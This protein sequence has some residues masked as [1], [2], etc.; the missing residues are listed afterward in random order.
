MSKKVTLPPDAPADTEGN[1][2]GG[3]WH[4]TD[5]N[6]KIR[7]QLCPRGCVLAPGAR[8]FCFVRQNRNG[9]LVLTTYGRSTGF[10]IDP[11]E[12]KPLN[13]FY[14]GTPILSFG[15]AGCNLGCKFCQNWTTTKS[16]EVDAYCD[17]A[18][19]EAIAE[20]A[21]QH[22]CR[23]VAFTYN[24]P[25]VWAEYAIDTAKHCR[26]R[27]IKTV[28]VTSGYISQEAR[29]PFFQ[30]MD[31]ANVDLKGFTE[32][33]YSKY[34]AGHLQPVLDTLQWLV[35]ESNVWV[36]ITNLIIPGANDSPEQLKRMCQWIASELGPDVPLHFTAFHP[37]FR[38]L[39]TPP[40]PISMLNAAYDIARGEGL[41]Y[42]YTGNVADAERQSTYCP[43]CGRV[44][45]ERNGYY[46]G[47]YALE[48]NRCRFC[49]T[50]IAGCYD[51]HGPGNWGGRRQPVRIRPIVRPNSPPDSQ[52]D[53]SSGNPASSSDSSPSQHR[54]RGGGGAA[55][56]E[57]ERPAAARP[58]KRTRATHTGKHLPATSTRDNPMEER[59]AS[60]NPSPE[61]PEENVSSED[62]GLNPGGARPNRPGSAGGGNQPAESRPTLTPE[63][64]QQLLQ[65]AAA[66]IT[67]SVTAGPTPAVHEALGPVARVPVL[68]V[69]VS[70]KR[71]GQ[72]R[73]CCGHMGQPALLG[74]AI[75]QAAWRT[76]TSDPRF[77][78]ISPSELRH[79][80][81]ELWVLWGL[82]R[83]EARGEDRAKWVEIG[84]HGL[85]IV[86]GGARGLLLPGVAVEHELDSVGFL[87]QVCL[88]AGLPPDAWKS[89]EAVV[90]T[91][92]GYPIRAPLGQFV[93]Q[94]PLEPAPPGPSEQQ[95]Q[96]VVDWCRQNL[97]ATLVGA[98][99]SFYLPGGYDD[100]VCGVILRVAPAGLA[101]AVE[102]QRIV[103]RPELPFQATLYDLVRAAAQALQ[104]RGVGAH[105]VQT[106]GLLVAVLWDTAMHGSLAAAEVGDLNTTRRALMVVQQNRW[107]LAFDPEKDPQQ[108]LAIAGQQVRAPNR[109][110]ASVFSFRIASTEHPLLATNVARPQR[111]PAVRR[112]A[113]AGRFY[114]G[115][116]QKLDQ[117]L[118][119]LLP[120]ERSPQPWPGCLVPHAGWQYSGRLAAAVLSRVKI[121]DRVIVLAPKH[122]PVGADWAIAP[123][124]T[125][126]LPGR[127]IASDPDLAGRL[128]EAI[129]GLELDAAAHSQEHAIEVQL[130][131]LARLAPE[132]KVLGITIHG[133][134]FE[135]LQRFAEQLAGV[136]A[137]QSE[138]PLLVVS[139]D[140]NHYADETT[141]RRLD[142]MALD[143]LEALDPQ[144]L[145]NTV[146]Q[147]RISMCGVIPT[148]VM[149]I[150]LKEL[151]RLQRAELVGYTTSAETT[152]DSRRVVGYA[153]MLFG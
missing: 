102:V 121:P 76:A 16:R 122:R 90:M 116:Q 126:A 42:V 61:K 55:D 113:V 129:D 111:G 17:T 115:D 150:A 99:P 68:G 69:F 47:Q 95:L 41:H 135:A 50:T 88:K 4:Q 5:E 138:L 12:K 106:A 58:A 6:G 20:A 56:S 141:T 123:H 25:I 13:Q 119:Q 63:Q 59:P 94:V 79:L 62:A 114:P 78:P 127:N 148:V 153:G 112:P 27:G 19:P 120:G 134:D 117:A 40:T 84:K 128:A 22:G 91:F 109:Q 104:R 3:W 15:T 93:G 67:A 60:G 36:E 108:L 146:H 57:Q 83:I 124:Q 45:I 105:V 31:A 89:N 80:D 85:Q 51:E 75:L 98:T 10:C 70:L 118:D 53:K 43:N 103:L 147:Q 48:G 35:H 30:W 14:P 82:K 149:M 125:W 144:R 152:R 74:E 101:E 151:G 26:R 65:Q 33:F 46:L 87:E 66:V 132:A 21:L 38:M 34:C 18:D 130:P 131:L 77:P 64:E 145:Y 39:D 136:L 1:K 97:V 107:A 49:G 9:E 81:M 71:A 139:T 29:E 8:G 52:L 140:M 137:E 54:R 32:D 2:P 37:D 44:I 96:T 72:L 92:E 133:G 11:I 142:R 23:S 100:Q 110:R 86:R 24:D 7:C 143:C 73:S 28:A